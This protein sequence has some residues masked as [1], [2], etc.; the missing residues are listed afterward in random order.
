MKTLKIL[1]R[2]ERLLLK[3]IK[4]GEWFYAVFT[5]MI[6]LFVGVITGVPLFM[7]DFVFESER[8][9]QSMFA[10][11]P[12][13]VLSLDL[14]T[15]TLRFQHYSM[16]EPRH[17]APYAMNDQQRRVFRLILLIGDFRSG[18]YLVAFMMFGLF[19]AFYFSPLDILVNGA[20]WVLFFLATSV[21]YSLIFESS[22][23]ILMKYRQHIIGIFFVFLFVINGLN[24]SKMQHWY[25]QFPLTG[26][27]GNGLYAIIQKDRDVA[28]L[29]MALLLLVILIGWFL[30]VTKINRLNS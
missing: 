6:C 20:Y 10:F 24:I 28:V 4:W 18:P 5:L 7:P 14:V 19:F 17:L 3:R 8:D 16:I 9:F 21:W 26:F 30:P 22:A 15:T 23:N 29:N 13:L 2:T 1:L 11:I 27:V 12:F 25:S